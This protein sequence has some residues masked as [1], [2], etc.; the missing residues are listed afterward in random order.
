MDSSP[1]PRSFESSERR[2]TRS[3]TLGA[4]A[5]LLGL[6]RL[7]HGE[8]AA[9]PTAAFRGVVAALGL[10]MTLEIRSSHSFGPKVVQIRMDPEAL[11]LLH[12]S[13]RERRI[14]DAAITQATQQNDLGGRI[15]RLH[16]DGERVGIRSDGF[17][18]EDWEEFSTE[19]EAGLRN[20]PAPA[21][22]FK[23]PPQDPPAKPTR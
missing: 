8:G 14:P 11:I 10:F 18:E 12:G 6:T 3:N 5:A 20:V 22:D 17:S 15:W 4:L 19:L 9:W 16:V 1:E 23:M 21:D 2:S 13:G 7:A